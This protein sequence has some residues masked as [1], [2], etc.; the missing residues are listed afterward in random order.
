MTV[1]SIIAIKLQGKKVGPNQMFYF[2]V[3]D[4]FKECIAPIWMFFTASELF[5]FF[6]LMVFVGWKWSIG[7]KKFIFLVINIY[8]LLEAGYF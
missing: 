7:F 5:G 6:Y 1:Q 3:S 8:S 2:L 4:R